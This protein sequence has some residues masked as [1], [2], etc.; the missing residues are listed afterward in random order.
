[1]ALIL[2]FACLSCLASM[3]GFAGTLSGWLVDAKCYASMLDNRNAPEV[4]WDGNL[5]IRYCTPDKK[6]RS[7][8]V[9]RWDDGSNFNLN[10]A[11]NEKAA[12]LPLSTEKK[13][14][15]RVNLTGETS[16]D[17]VTVNAISIVKQINR[18][19]HAAPGL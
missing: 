14:V 7:F 15:Y 10:P 18:T 19:G 6:T 1:M 2:R 12:E 11:G 17:T 8:S 13:F 4:S 16:R 9:V 5:A 3:L